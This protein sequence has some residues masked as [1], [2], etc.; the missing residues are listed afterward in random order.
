MKLNTLWGALVAPL[1]LWLQFPAFSHN[2]I[3]RD[4][5]DVIGKY[6]SD[7]VGSYNAVNQ[8]GIKGGHGVL[9]YSGHFSGLYPGENLTDKT[10][11][12]IM[13][14]QYD[15]RT[16]T[17]QQ[18][19]DQRRLH[20]VGRYQFIGRTLASL[21]RRHNISLDDKFTPELQ[22]K[23]AIIL[24]NEAGLGSWIGPYAYANHNERLIVK[25]CR[26]TLK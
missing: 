6:E 2:S 19:L 10:V 22:D 24:L 7:P 15:D 9:G 25:Q 17:N 11:G 1:F 3:C 21:V 20:A 14:L 12:E 26:A 18:W 23:L 8:I 4:A 5:L 16:L 13:A